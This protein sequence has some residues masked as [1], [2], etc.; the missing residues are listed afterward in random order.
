M[1][2]IYRTAL[3][4]ALIAV[5]IQVALAPF[6]DVMAAGVIAMAI[7]LGREIAQHEY[8]I[9]VQRGWRWGQGAKPVKWYDGIIGG[10]SKDSLLDLIFP[11]IAVS[12][13][14]TGWWVYAGA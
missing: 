9:A 8:K 2:I 13:V 4:H 14:A 7:F 6:T 1:P 5:V 12:A 11:L 10:W 3:E